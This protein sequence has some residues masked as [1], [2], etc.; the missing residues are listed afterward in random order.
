MG[1]KRSRLCQRAVFT[2]VLALL[3]TVAV[4]FAAPSPAAAAT[5]LPTGFT[6]TQLVSGLN[7]PYQMEFAPDGRLF[8]SQQ[9][10]RLRVIKNGALL[11]VPFVTVAVDSQGDRGMI[12]IAF[13]PA[14]T[15]N[16]FVYVYYTSPTPA[17]H[18][19]VSR[20]TAN[21]D[22]AVAGSEKV[23]IELPNLGV[24]T[25]H[26]GGSIHFGADG[27]LYISVGDNV[28]GAVAQS[29]ASL[30]GKVLR[31]NSDGTIPPDNP[32][33][34]ALNGSFRAIWAVGLRN[35]YTFGIQ[36]GTGRIF[37]DD[38]GASTWEEI[39]DG[40]AGANYGWPITE[41]VTTDPRFNSPLFVYGHGSTPTTGCAIAGGTFYN[42]AVRNFPTS[43][44]GKYFFGDACGGWIHVLDPV[45]KT[46]QQFM[47]AGAG[48]ID[49]KTGP[50]GSL[51]YLARLN[52]VNDPGFVHKITFSAKP[53]I[54]SP[55][56]S[57]TVLPGE[58]ATFTVVATGQT[59]LSYQWQRGGV[60]I[61]GARSASYT[62]SAPTLTDNG[63]QFRVVVT[64]PLG[65]T[66]SASA[67]LTVTT[68]RPPTGTI[69]TPASGG[70]Y[71]AGDTIS[72]SASAT[73]AEDG[74]LPA[75]AYS[76][77]VAFH[78]NTHTHPGPSIGPGPT[79]DSKSGTF[80][81]PDTGETS[82]DVFYR[83]HLTVTDSGG[84]STTS[85]VDVLPN[86][87]TLNF[88]ATPTTPNDGLQIL[89]D[90]QPHLTP[91]AE[92]SVAGMKRNLAVD[93]PQLLDTTTY[94]FSGWSDGGAANHQI[95]TPAAVT[96]YTAVFVPASGDPVAAP[97]RILD[98]RPDGVTVDGRFAGGGERAF[99]STLELL[100][101]GRAGLPTNATSV[102]LN[103]TATEA[104]GSGFITVFPCEAGRPT[105]SNLNYVANANVSNMVIAKVGTGGL[106]CLFNSAATNLVVDVTGD[107]PAVDA[108][109]ALA[110]PARLLDTR[111]DSTTLDGAY[112]GDGLR[113]TGSVQVLQVSGRAGV[114]VGVSS[115]V[116][117]VTVDQ[118]EI[119]G[120]ITVYPCDA[121]IPTASNVNYVAAQTVAN[122][123]ISKLSDAGT[124]C[125]FN[126]GATHLVVDIAGYFVDRSVVVPLGEPARLLDTRAGGNTID[127][128]F[129]GTGLRPSTGTIQLSVSGRA[130]IPADASAVV[131]NVTV[132][133]AQGDGFITVYPTGVDRPNAS[134]LNYLVDQTVPNAVIT[135]LGSGGS[136]CLY[137]LGA[138]HLV[139]DVAGYLTGP[140]PVSAGSCPA[141]PATPP[142]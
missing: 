58:P 135:R 106:V 101:A 60:N 137:N 17:S 26:N 138:T 126:S 65:S 94:A 42:P 43:Y 92:D 23:L 90:D 19:R 85:F 1:M 37:I 114:P 87:T 38:V 52:A 74:T 13:D 120:F 62:L 75:S 105:A 84:R 71:N 104:Q 86:T 129:S 6:D 99:G 18:N 22:V 53:A 30:L 11:S 33:F 44:V 36:P 61:A 131:L 119:A 98:T 35:P 7:R 2:G 14:F 125:L 21:G 95:V 4:T 108:F 66:T 103:V 47:S 20:F 76:W 93:S 134:N 100:V 118:P 8:V 25:L 46:A 140:A 78:H 41:G 124:V 63:A 80:V 83:I 139:V 122:A 112:L 3:V 117:N 51:Y 96:T 79:G 68:N 31:I 136:V 29:K 64:N 132:D 121:G 115:A 82:T 130:G 32:Y 24:S 142:T 109:T 127:G 27:K 39:D 81:V 141:D 5:V 77:E 128:A 70:H 110:D 133:Q 73:D 16:H 102:V 59:P 57:T 45:A 56:V 40:V 107:F 72:F 123:V 91:Y 67:T 54:A 89:L 116:L 12:G 69:V 88:H 9:G 111:P 113:T 55:P 15:A 10:G 50:D 28:Q 48:V 97:A 34:S 49:V